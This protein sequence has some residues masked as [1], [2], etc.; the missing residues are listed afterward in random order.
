MSEERQKTSQIQLDR[1]EFFIVPSSFAVRICYSTFFF[2][3]LRAETRS[4]LFTFR[5][6]R[7]KVQ[8]STLKIRNVKQLKLFEVQVKTVH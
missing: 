4:S 8:K 5:D 2:S 3:F 6:A 1:S 7:F